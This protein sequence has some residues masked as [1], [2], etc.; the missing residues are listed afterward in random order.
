MNSL[1]KVFTI[2]GI[3][4]S[5]FLIQ[6]CKK[7]VPTAPAITTNSVIEVTSTNATSGGNVT[8]E[9]GVPVLARGICW[10][11]TGTP[12]TEDTK[13]IEAGRSGLFRSDLYQLTPNT[14]YFVRAYATNS[15]GTG[16]GSTLSFRTLEATP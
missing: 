13:N 6:A 3:I 15:I 9:G 1:E 8:S 16:Y 7:V 12:T 14:L 2:S 5:I 10:N 4:L 11:T